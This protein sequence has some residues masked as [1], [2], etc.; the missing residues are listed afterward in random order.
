MGV[1]ISSNG[2]ESSAGIDVS[3]LVPF[4]ACSQPV[5]YRAN[6]LGFRNNKKSGIAKIKVQLT[7]DVYHDMGAVVLILPT[8]CTK[9]NLCKNLT[10]AA[11][12]NFDC[13]HF[14]SRYMRSIHSEFIW[15]KCLTLRHLKNF[16]Y[17]FTSHYRRRI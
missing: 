7:D 3:Q 12:K 13:Y 10:A 6:I 14:G 9:S 8:F 16:T 2:I 4:L 5:D 15:S 1:F 11:M 17:I